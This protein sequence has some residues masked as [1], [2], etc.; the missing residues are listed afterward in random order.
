MNDDLKIFTDGAAY[1]RT[2]GRWSRIV[3]REFLDWLDAPK[4]LRW[5]DVGCGNGAFTETLMSHAAPAHV[6][7]IDPSPPQIAYARQRDTARPAV[8]QVGDAQALPF[9]DADFDATIMALVIS[10]IPDPAKAVAQM[11]RVTRPGGFVG[12]YMWHNRESVPVGPLTQAAKAL[13]HDGDYVLLRENTASQEGMRAL[14]HDAGLEDIETRRI[15]I[16]VTFDDFDDFWES[17]NALPNPANQFMRGLSEA[18]VEA[19][20]DWLRDFLPTDSS[21]RIS[22]HASANAV[23]GRVK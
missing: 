4:G 16:P 5:L 20:R 8:F 2:M 14:W 15:D 17:S 1:E 9:A 12:A 7:G 3:G 18:Q 21:G 6:S 11:A 10:F 23:K 22:F 13:G 19:V